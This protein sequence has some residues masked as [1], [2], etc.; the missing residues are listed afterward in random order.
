MD[1]TP[2]TTK[3]HR[4]P[5]Q[6][7]SARLGDPDFSPMVRRAVI[8][9]VVGWIVKVLTMV[10]VNNDLGGR[11]E[12]RRWGPGI[13]YMAFEINRPGFMQITSASTRV[14]A[15]VMVVLLVGGL[16]RNKSKVHV[17]GW[18]FAP[19]S[20][21]YT[22]ALDYGLHRWV[23]DY[24]DLRR[25]HLGAWLLALSLVLVAW[26]IAAEHPHERL[27]RRRIDAR[28]ALE[29]GNVETVTHSV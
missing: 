16:L 8:V 22:L 1:T 12:I 14:M 23:G 7:G 6:A 11:M 4:A 5:A 9:A 28:E 29:L 20:L 3:T 2:P 10:K 24:T 25:L 18:C 17:A 26:W 21:A 15:I 13:P 27:V 19:V